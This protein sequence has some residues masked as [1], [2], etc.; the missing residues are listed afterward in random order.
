ML[1][2][3]IVVSQWDLQTQGALTVER[4]QSLFPPDAGFRV[5]WDRFTDRRKFASVHQA[6]T[7]YVLKGSIAY[8]STSGEFQF[9][10][11]EVIQLPAERC[12]IQVLGPDDFEYVSVFDLKSSPR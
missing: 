2:K 6:Y 3:E 4:L 8:H 9:R 10:Q 5:V 12:E 11:N 1:N 7:W